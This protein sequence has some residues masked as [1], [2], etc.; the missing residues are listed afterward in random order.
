MLVLLL[1]APPTRAFLPLF[2]SQSGASDVKKPSTD[3][4]NETRQLC[5]EG[6]KVH[7]N[8][9][10]IDVV[11]CRLRFAAGPSPS[12]TKPAVAIPSH[13]RVCKRQEERVRAVGAGVHNKQTDARPR[14]RDP[15]RNAFFAA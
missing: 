10:H 7:P 6:S 9:S 11:R 2:S 15:R 14:L 8:Y 13:Q 12:P 4:R 3:M 5:E 1:L